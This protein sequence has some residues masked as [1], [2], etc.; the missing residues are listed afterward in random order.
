MKVIL[1]N[2]K[3]GA[4]KSFIGSNLHWHLKNSA[5]IEGDAF[6]QINPFT[7]TKENYNLV[8]KSIANQVK[9]YDEFKN[10]EYV[11]ISWVIWH[12]ETYEILKENLKDF[13]VYEIC[14]DCPNNQLEKRVK[15]DIENNKRHSDNL[16]KITRQ[17][18]SDGFIKISSNQDLQKVIDEISTI[19]NEKETAINN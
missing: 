17:I 15:N 11:I 9:T 6:L 7:P 2:G 19:I 12:K 16:Q 4:G 14:L 3:I 5:F 8:A 1:L 13:D 10:I 18:Y